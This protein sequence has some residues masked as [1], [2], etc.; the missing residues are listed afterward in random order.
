[1]TYHETIDYLYRA[2]PM[3][4]RIGPKNFKPDLK[5]TQ[6]LCDFLMHPERR[7]T[8][9]HVAGTNGKGSVC[10]MLAA[11]FQS[12]GYKTGLFTSPHLIDFR[13]RI[14]INGEMIPEQKVVDF[15]Q[16]TRQ[17]AE[18]EK[19]SFFEL[20]FGMALDYFWKEKTE[21]VI[22]ETGLG[23]RLDSTNVVRPKL[24]IITNIGMDHTETL[25]DTLEKI[26]GEK[27]GIIKTRIPVV[28]GEGGAEINPVFIQTAR[29]M[30]APLIFS[31]RI[32]DLIS[33][34]M[35]G[36]FLQVEVRNRMIGEQQAYK[37]DLTGIY[38]EQNL[39][40]VLAAVDILKF[41]FH[42]ETENVKEGLSRVKELTGLH[43][44]WEVLSHE[45][46][47]VCDVAHNA[48]GITQMLRQLQR[49]SFH[50]IHILIGMVKDKDVNKVLSL[51]PPDAAYYFT[52]AETPRALEENLLQ[53]KALKFRLKGQAYPTISDA[54]DSA[55]VQASKED[56]ILVCG[57]VF[58]VG[59]ALSFFL[60][61]TGMAESEHA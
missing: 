39:L 41:D 2:L 9:I 34:E 38:Q 36:S 50:K 42:L 6:A 33:S 35:S 25:G 31:E 59:E 47:V 37:L 49:S 10:S 43:G 26:A 55:I 11:I 29:K 53:D 28:I 5:K 21:I 12:H 22:F 14:K 20:T 58:V 32:F 7:I 4:S 15:V 56:L 45:P 13:E 18:T 24:S 19:L 23:G 51:L 16:K 3:F 60:K 44:R 1:M 46:L 8:C 17:F 61:R 57:S 27:A 54:L 52:R 48:E 40:P 30:Q